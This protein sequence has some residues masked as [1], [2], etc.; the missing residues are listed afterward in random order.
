MNGAQVIKKSE[1]KSV[2][3]FTW[4]SSVDVLFAVLPRVDSNPTETL[5]EGEDPVSIRS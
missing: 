3:K 5:M 4:R 1:W 2:Q